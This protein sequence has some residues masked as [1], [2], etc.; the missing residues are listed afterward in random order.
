MKTR[1]PRLTEKMRGKLRLL[2]DYAAT[3]A[4]QMTEDTS[5]RVYPRNHEDASDYYDIIDACEWITRLAN[6]GRTIS[7]GGDR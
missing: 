3:E 6:S 4:H 5:G 7:Q 2:A 1:R